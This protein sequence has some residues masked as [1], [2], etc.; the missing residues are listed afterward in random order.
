M[1]GDWGTTEYAMSLNAENTQYTEYMITGIVAGGGD[2]EIKVVYQNGT[3]LTY[4]STLKNGVDSTIYSK[5]NYDANIKLNFDGSYD[6]YFDTSVNK[7]WL[8]F[9]VEL[10]SISAEFNGRT[11]FVGDKL[12]NS[13]FE[14]YAH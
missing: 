14:V 2:D 10:V 13:D 3:N 8:Q 1:N 9:T 11:I 6:I 4:Y 5:E 7:I 12:E